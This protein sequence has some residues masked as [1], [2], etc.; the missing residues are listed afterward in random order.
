MAEMHDEPQKDEAPD[1]DVPISPAAIEWYR[2]THSDLPE[3][4]I[5]NTGK[6]G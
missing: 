5:H 2:I 3:G 4:D 6:E 1:T